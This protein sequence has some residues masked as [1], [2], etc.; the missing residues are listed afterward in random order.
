MNNKRHTFHFYHSYYLKDTKVF[1]SS[2]SGMGM[3]TRYMFLV[4]IT[5]SQLNIFKILF[6]YVINIIKN[7]FFYTKAMKSSIYFIVIV[8]LN[9]E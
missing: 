9:S 2:R 8:Q 1:R 5:V 7:I 6:S 4:S 3:K